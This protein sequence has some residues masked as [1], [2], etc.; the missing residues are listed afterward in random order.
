MI[1]NIVSCIDYILYAYFFLCVGYIALFSAASCRKRKQEY[2]VTSR[3]HRFIFLIPAYKEDKVIHESAS[4]AIA[5]NYPPE[6]FDV[7][8]ISDKMTEETNNALRQL[9]AEVLSIHF[10]ESS[11]STALKTAM[12]YLKGRSPYDYVVVLDADNVVSENYLEEINKVIV[13]SGCRMLQTHRIAK[14]INT[15]TAILD[16]AIEEMNNSI[17][18]AGH[19]NLGFSSALIGSGMVMDYQWFADNI[20]HTDSVGEDKELEELLLRQRIHTAYAE[21]IYV[22]DEKVQEKEALRNQRRRWIA[23]QF[24]LANRMRKHLPE[25]IRTGNGD[26]IIKAIQAYTLPRSI[27][28]GLLGFVSLISLFIPSIASSKWWGLLVLLLISMY[29]AI[30]SS[31]KNK[32]LFK[33]IKN[34]PYFVYIMILNLFHIKG[35][36][37]KFIHTQ[38]G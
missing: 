36:A 20:I 35:A 27:L 3:L 17:F 28:L 4:S 9:G 1:A 31:M 29:I 22:W 7:L 16:A 11:K 2:A 37:K 23:A 12:E 26:Y 14:N 21:H 24:L 19:V 25:A 34:I 15:S 10:Q 30:P 38:H 8:V 5:Q 32:E 18:R 13:H 33:A 6:L